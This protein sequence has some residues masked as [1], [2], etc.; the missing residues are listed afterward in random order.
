M[1]FFNYDLIINFLQ[2]IFY[3]YFLKAKLAGHSAIPIQTSEENGWKLS[4]GR[5]VVLI[6]L[7]GLKQTI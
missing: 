1:H 2:L 5:D 3:H 7:G 6:L 4:A